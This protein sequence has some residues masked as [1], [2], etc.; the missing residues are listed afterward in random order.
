MTVVEHVHLLEDGASGRPIP[1][2]LPIHCAGCD[3]RVAVAI[4]RHSFEFRRAIVHLW[5]CPICHRANLMKFDGKILGA[6]APW[7]ERRL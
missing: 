6:P 1:L 7:S 5:D 3:Q 4:E 2:T